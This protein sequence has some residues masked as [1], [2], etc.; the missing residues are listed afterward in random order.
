MRR[1]A[2]GWAAV[3]LVA[4][5]E[6]PRTE[7]V[8][9]VESEL[10]WGPVQAVQSVVLTVRRGSATGPL[11]S[12]RTTVLGDGGER[13]PLP[14]LVGVTAA[15]DDV[16]T[17]VWV[18]A[19]GCGDP[20]GCT[21]ATAVVAQRAVVRFAR[22]ATQEV[23]LLLASACVGVTCALD[24]RCAVASRRCEPATRAQDELR[25]FAG[26]DAATV[27]MDTG[28]ITRPDATTDAGRDAS[29]DAPVDS[30]ASNDALVDSAASVDAADAVL[31]VLVELDR[32]TDLGTLVDAGVDAARDVATVDVTADLGR[33]VPPDVSGCAATLATGAPCI[34]PVTGHRWNPDDPRLVAAG[35]LAVTNDRLYVS[36][37]G[38]ARVMAYD[39]SVSPLDPT[40]LVGTGLVGAA[41]VGGAPRATAV[42]A[43]TSMALLPGGTVLFA[44]RDAH[45]VLRL[46]DG[47]LDPLALPL[48][49]PTGPFALSYAP[50]TRELFIAGDNRLH[51]VPFDADGGVG[52]PVTVVGQSCGA[53]CAGFNG[54]GMPG[55]S[56]ALAFP[57]GVD[58]DTTYVYFSDRDNCRVRRVRR[59]DPTH[60]VE[61]FAGS[62]CDLT[63]DP[64][65]S[66]STGFVPREA[67]RLGR[68]TDVR[69]GV[70]GSVYFVDAS[71]CAV[72]QVVASAL[73]TAR[74]V[75]GSR[76]GCNQPTGTGGLTVGRIGGIAMSADRG[77]LYVSDTQQQ[78]VLRV[79][80]TA[81]GGTPRVSVALSPGAAPRIDEDAAFLRAG[82]P[83]GLAVLTTPA[84]LLLTG[85][86]EGRL[87]RVDAARA[88]VVFGEGAAAPAPM[89]DALAAATLPPTLVAGL[90][91]D[92][93]HALVGMPERGVIADLTGL[94][95]AATLERVAG[96]Y[97]NES[98][99]AGAP[100]GAGGVARETT[101]VR[102]A[103]PFT[104]GGVTWFSDAAA[105]VWRVS[106]AGAAE[107]FAGSGAGT[108]TLPAGGTVAAT[109]APLGSAVGFALD[110]GGTLYIADP[111]RFVVWAVSSGVARLAAGVLDR[112]APLGDDPNPA[113]ALG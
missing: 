20:N 45:Q 48:S 32:P 77:T 105:R 7:L 63:G 111:Q 73:T 104:Q 35:A 17:P 112:P 49:F 4:G 1:K 8:V 47:R 109:A 82:Q 36:D 62:T 25:P 70:D 93:T 81:S 101:F 89:A 38:S 59:A 40:R 28:P 57:V 39:L 106:T 3:A 86:V 56:T 98:L 46:R 54:D 58:V 110:R 15:D 11:R 92:G 10:A 19:L 29:M 99:D 68:V 41:L 79:E 103:W 64:L 27:A 65:G 44:D 113:T 5:C 9:R 24:E 42:S 61:T 91:G 60:V 14:L 96:R 95:A 69:Y 88:R 12:A 83:T 18:E 51:V 85:A 71:H 50:D 94:G 30:G 74:I 37:L 52:T 72:F 102:P 55:T 97:A 2:W 75:L 26:A 78:R 43:V 21:A 90:A 33:D 84:T 53:S 80:G 13:R 67:L 76:Y 107:P 6:Q 66:S 87:Y 108:A 34:E 16:E 100:G 31:D 23:T 22:G